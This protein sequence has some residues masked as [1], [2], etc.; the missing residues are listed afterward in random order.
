MDNELNQVQ[1]DDLFTDEDFIEEST[2]ETH[3]ELEGKPAEEEIVDTPFLEITYDKEKK[4]LSKEEATTYA[5]KGMNYDRLNEKYNHI[6][7]PLENLA[8]KNG[9]NVEDF[10]ENLNQTQIKYETDLAYKQLKEKHPDADDGLLMEYA[11][12]QIQNRMFV[13]N[14]QELQ[15]QTEQDNAQKQRVREDFNRFRQELPNVDVNSLP[16][17]VYENVKQGHDLLSAYYKY[18][19]SELTKKLEESQKQAEI[20]KQNKDNLKRSLGS[21]TSASGGETD[22]FLDGLFSD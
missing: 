12:E 19:Y 22:A 21:T 8:K 13:N 16:N 2:E 9:M 20:D 17:E 10:L 11:K 1:N 3:E 15:K 14:Q 6:Y 7:S 4:G 18:Q 5:Q